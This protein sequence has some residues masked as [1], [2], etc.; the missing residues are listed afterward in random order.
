MKSGK[1]VLGVLAGLATGAAFGILF[2]PDK[3]KNTRK[4]IGKKKD[5]VIDDMRVKLNHLVD[6]A[7]EKLGLAKDKATDKVE[8]GKE[9]V[10]Q[11][12]NGVKDSVKEAVS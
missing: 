7:S 11:T 2:A 12:K 5:A 8:K 10:D 9:L 4:K 6:D 3:G 1:V